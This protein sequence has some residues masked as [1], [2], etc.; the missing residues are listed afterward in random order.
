MYLNPTQFKYAAFA[1]RPD[2]KGL[3]FGKYTL[4]SG[5][6]SAYFWNAGNLMKTGEGAAISSEV[7]AELLVLGRRKGDDPDFLM[8]PAMKGIAIAAIMADE[9]AT[10]GI[11]KR[12]GFDIKE[13]GEERKEVKWSEILGEKKVHIDDEFVVGEIP[14]DGKAARDLGKEL[15][16][17]FSN[18]RFDVLLAQSYGG[19]VPAVLVVKHLYEH[20]KNKRFAYNRIQ[21]K[22]YADLKEKLI[23]GDVE[24]GDIAIVIK[25]KEEPEGPIV[26]DFIEGDRVAQTED[27]MTT[28]KTKIDAWEKLC[29]FRSG[30]EPGVIYLGLNRQEV[31]PD[32]EDP[33]EV[34]NEIGF[35]VYSAL[36]AR[37]V[38]NTFHMVPIEEGKKPP[39][40]DEIMESFREHQARF[41]SKRLE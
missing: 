28:A 13:K 26:G 41:G 38:M 15:S 9:L 33:I 31:T 25:S 32:G 18:K 37:D 7:Y 20:G 5:R 4:K 2:I 3:D 30:L 12:F 8:G 39:V 24:N 36:N 14:L 21:T 22:E 27:V 6:D 10:H 29:N 35:K 11:Y 40:T 16:E 19:I 34:L 23:V 17:K 1:L